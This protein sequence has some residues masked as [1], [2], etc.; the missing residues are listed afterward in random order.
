MAIEIHPRRLVGPWDSGYALD[1]HTRHSTFLGSNEA[2]HA[3]F[4]NDRSPIGELLSRLKY[5]GEQTALAP[6]VETVAM[7]LQTRKARPDA[8]VPVPPSNVRK[9]QPVLSIANA[10]SERLKIPV[11]DGCLATIKRTPQLKDISQYHKRLEALDG[12]FGV[13]VEQTRS[14]K[15]L[16]F[17]DLFGSGETVGAI[18]KVLKGPGEAEAVYLLTLTMK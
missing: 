11:C 8:I 14:K 1:V 5:K 15:L 10:V 7:F 3:Q 6:L 2:G 18:T 12:A 16:L 9:N 4:E 13:S 17:D